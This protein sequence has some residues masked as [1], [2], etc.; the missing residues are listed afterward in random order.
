M[1]ITLGITIAIIA[2]AVGFM[3][4]AAVMVKTP[5]PPPPQPRH[6]AGLHS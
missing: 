5:H 6:R 4:G 1:T 2:G 3:L